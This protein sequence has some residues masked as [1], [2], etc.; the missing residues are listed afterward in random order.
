MSHVKAGIDRRGR[1]AAPIAG[2]ALAAALWLAALPAGVA[3]AP[4]HSPFPA[5]AGVDGSA[6]AARIWAP[7]AFLVYVENDEDVDDHGSASRW[8]YLYFSPSLQKSRVYSLRD[9]AIV[10]AEDLE[11][12]FE[13]PPLAAEWVDSDAALA[14]ADERAGRAFCREH[15]GRLSQMLL[16]RGMFESDDPDATT[17]TVIYTSPH[18][19]SLFVLVDAAHGAVRRT[20]RG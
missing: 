5:G 18:A 13:A 17:W 7:D 9:G 11:M 2:S 12:K 8:G 14:A 4:D 1:A 20:W 19:A 3:G 16:S 15:H 10:V 6:A